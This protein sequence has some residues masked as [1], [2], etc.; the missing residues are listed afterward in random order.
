MYFFLKKNLENPFGLPFRPYRMDWGA[1]RDG[2]LSEERLVGVVCC[3][4]FYRDDNQLY[5]L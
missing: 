4:E 2:G 3:L 1:W 5:G